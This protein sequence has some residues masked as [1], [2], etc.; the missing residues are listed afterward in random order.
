MYI[1]FVHDSTLLWDLIDAPTTSHH[2]LSMCA[3]AFTNI[4]HNASKN[5]VGMQYATPWPRHVLIPWSPDHVIF[6]PSHL[7]IL[8]FHIHIN[9]SMHV[10]CQSLEPIAENPSIYSCLSRPIIPSIISSSFYTSSLPWFYLQNLEVKNKNIWEN[11]PCPMTQVHSKF[12]PI[13]IWNLPL[14]SMK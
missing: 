7:V 10:P 6:P 2:V 13:S 5:V 8:A 9:I 3:L 1:S 14:N 12:D 4:G 11:I